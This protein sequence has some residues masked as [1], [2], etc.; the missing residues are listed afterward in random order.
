MSY[1]SCH[2]LTYQEVFDLNALPS[3][4]I[5]GFQYRC[6]KEMNALWVKLWKV[7]T[8]TR[9]QMKRQCIIDTGLQQNLVNIR[10]KHYFSFVTIYWFDQVRHKVRI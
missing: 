6:D 2:L 10:R 8:F 3:L 1:A 5:G 4:S 9:E 7:G